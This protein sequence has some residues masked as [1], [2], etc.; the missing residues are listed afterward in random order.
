MAE[1][2]WKKTFSKIFLKNIKKEL[3]LRGQERFALEEANKSLYHN[4][5][6]FPELYKILTNET[7]SLKAFEKRE[8]LLSNKK[9]F[10]KLLKW[11]IARIR[12]KESKSLVSKYNTYFRPEKNKLPQKNF[13]KRP[14]GKELVQELKDTVFIVL[15]GF[16]SHLIDEP[17][18]METLREINAFY[19]RGPKR[20]K[21]K[22][23]GEKTLFMPH[24]EFYQKTGKPLMMDIIYPMGDEL[25]NT[26]GS[27]Q[28]NATK[29]KK[30]IENLPKAYH[31]KEIVFIGY[32]KGLT[33]AL[34]LVKD[35]PRI[36]KRT[37][38]I[39]SLSGPQQGS[40]N[41]RLVIKDL[42]KITG[43]QS[44]KEMAE[45]AKNLELRGFLKILSSKIN[46]EDKTEY[47]KLFKLFYLIKMGELPKS[48]LEKAESFLSEDSSIFFKGVIEQTPSY[49][50]KWNLEN[51]NDSYYK[52]PLS[53][54][55][56]SF[57][58]NVKDFFHKFDLKSQ[59][60][61]FNNELVP[62]IRPSIT[63][64]P[65]PLS[66]FDTGNKLA[67]FFNKVV[68]WKDFS[69]DSFIL[70]LTSI[71]AFERSPGGLM[72]TQIAW[73]D[74]KSFFLD[75]R[76]LAY[77]FSKKELLKIYQNLDI[78]KTNL[79]FYEF[80]NNERR[81]LISKGQR[82]NL[83]FVD[84]GELRGTHWNIPLTQ[85]ARIPG[86]HPKLGHVN[87]F[88]RKPLLISILQTY[89]LYKLEKNL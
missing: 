87:S 71:A 55:S 83:N 10:S 30:W 67:G 51:L 41:L 9:T 46:E 7:S 20:P 77:Q 24:N 29:L 78:D 25:G 58:T 63:E 13:F 23:F 61:K 6:P 79:T 84:L 68:Y 43:R 35:S 39:F 38:A 54:F 18:F 28:E 74:S 49:R 45:L 48:L 89:A 52:Y 5:R 8:S 17:P 86:S 2:F 16:G 88:P 26:L 44:L 80:L 82:K 42:M 19:G 50:L 3:S 32:S 69:L 11:P 1:T 64:K 75:H 73:G 76:P 12:Y 56:V 40:L 66:S 57:L 85:A 81:S 70:H 72:D 65:F 60:F 22:R 4:S 53:I 59:R 31:G 37:K 36:Q 14:L 27:H 33:L 34:E 47:Q 62:R 21:I 15:S